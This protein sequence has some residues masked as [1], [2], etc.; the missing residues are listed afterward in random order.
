[1]KRVLLFIFLNNLYL[2]SMDMKIKDG[3]IRETPPNVVNSAAFMTL[4][5]TSDKDV[6]VVNAIS[7]ISKK[8]ELH[9]HDMKNGVMKMYKIPQIRIKA[10]SQ[11]ILKPGGLHVMFIGLH[12][13]LKVG[14]R[15]TFSFEL[16]DGTKQ[17]VTLPI[18]TVI[19]GLR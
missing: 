17:K 4:K 16:S 1:M 5:N 13:P 12:K 7:S 8:V 6:I 11:I 18:K 14:E 2:F 19:D 3:Y 10:N 9:T 15:V